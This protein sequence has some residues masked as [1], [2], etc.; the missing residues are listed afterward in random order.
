MA[1]PLPQA[2]FFSFS[3][4]AQHLSPPR[5]RKLTPSKPGS[6]HQGVPQVQK[7]HSWTQLSAGPLL[8]AKGNQHFSF[9]PLPIPSPHN[10]GWLRRGKWYSVPGCQPLFSSQVPKRCHF[11]VSEPSWTSPLLLIPQGL[12]LAAESRADLCWT[13]EACQAQTLC[14]LYKFYIS[15]PDT[16]IQSDWTDRH[17]NTYITHKLAAK[18]AQHSVLETCLFKAK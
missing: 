1:K 10:L 9:L 17:I 14:R 12:N 6:Q 2:H 11:S 16:E 4:S 18:I 15:L 3:S 5:I 8:P 13:P 7:K